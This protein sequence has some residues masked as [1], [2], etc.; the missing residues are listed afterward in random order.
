MDFPA[1]FKGLWEKKWNVPLYQLLN[2]VSGL[3]IKIN[4]WV[5][6]SYLASSTLLY[7][8]R[9]TCVHSGCRKWQIAR[10]HFDMNVSLTNR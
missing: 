10:G 7:S 1:I 3:K 2:I 4:G 6:F 9:D 5:E 8:N